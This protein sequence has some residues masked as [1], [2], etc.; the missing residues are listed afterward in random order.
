MYTTELKV[1]VLRGVAP[2]EGRPPGPNNE[3]GPVYRRHDCSFSL[4]LACRASWYT[5]LRL[6]WSWY[7]WLAV[8]SLVEVDQCYEVR[9]FSDMVLVLALV[10]R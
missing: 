5:L 2:F 9:H 4:W 1:P 10:L 7:F 6:N 3:F 8:G